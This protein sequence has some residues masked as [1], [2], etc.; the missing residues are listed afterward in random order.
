MFL[1]HISDT[2]AFSV[3]LGI[4]S[5]QMAFGSAHMGVYTR[6]GA[7]RPLLD[8]AV[9]ASGERLRWGESPPSQ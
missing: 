8:Q 6:V 9:Q 4:A 5:S 2:D 3:L 1:G 7:Y